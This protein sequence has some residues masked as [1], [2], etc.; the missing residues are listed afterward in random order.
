[1]DGLKIIRVEN[2]DA[3]IL[4]YFSH[5]ALYKVLGE[6]L[7]RHGEISNAELVFKQGI[8]RDPS[9]LPLY[10]ACALFQGALGNIEVI[11]PN[12]YEEYNNGYMVYTG[13]FEFT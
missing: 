4:F 1:M 10:H 11:F 12:S 3:D 13:T 8:Q 2:S 6:L 5:G 7:A 9:Y